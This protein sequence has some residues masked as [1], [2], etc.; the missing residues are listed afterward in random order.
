MGIRA[1]LPGLPRRGLGES[2]AGF[3]FNDSF[4]P[5]ASTQV[6]H[7]NGLSRSFRNQ[8]VRHINMNTKTY[9]QATARS[10]ESLLRKEPMTT[11]G[12][13]EVSLYGYLFDTG[14]D[15][16]VNDQIGAIDRSQDLTPRER[17]QLVSIL[18]AFKPKGLRSVDYHTA[19]TNARRIKIQTIYEKVTNT[20]ADFE[21]RVTPDIQNK[22]PEF[23]ESLSANVE[24]LKFS[25]NS[26]FT[27]TFQRDG[28][29]GDGV[30]TFKY[31]ENVDTGEGMDAMAKTVSVDEIAN[32]VNN[33]LEHPQG[34]AERELYEVGARLKARKQLERDITEEELA[35]E[36]EKIE[37]IKAVLRSG[38]V[39]SNIRLTD[40]LGLSSKPPVGMDERDVFDI[41][42][43]QQEQAHINGE[44]IQ[45]VTNSREYTAYN[46]NGNEF[47]RLHGGATAYNVHSS[48]NSQDI[49][50]IENASTSSLHPHHKEANTYRDIMDKA[51]TAEQKVAAALAKA[52]RELKSDADTEADKVKEKTW[53][54]RYPYVCFPLIA[55]GVFITVG[56]LAECLGASGGTPDWNKCANP[57][58]ERCKRKCFSD[59][60]DPSYWDAGGLYDKPTDGR[61]GKALHVGNDE[62]D[63]G[64]QFN[65]QWALVMWHEDRSETNPKDRYDSMNRAAWEDVPDKGLYCTTENLRMDPGNTTCDGYCEEACADAYPDRGFGS[66]FGRAA[67]EVV[68]LGVQGGVEVSKGVFD[69]IF[70]DNFFNGLLFVILLLV[71]FFLYKSF[72]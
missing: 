30:I 49:E 28:D 32:I 35:D 41:A 10:V 40:N 26:E 19:I 36:I 65:T 31:Y 18:P 21:P 22:F 11:V 67:R 47:G 68:K 37:D 72:K 38:S 59:W 53:C 4:D 8:A 54:A 1:D 9:D 13:N 52:R 46:P 15:A 25:K 51:E 43:Y 42:W 16:N 17:L 24:D 12:V 27:F 33:D 62:Y 39:Y 71:G 3:G 20:P 70:G 56:E 6:M 14:K 50:T 34:L 5:G 29:G 23:S 48:T 63:D 45:T 66:I 61:V 55:M 69:G 7:G 58:K 2:S 57:A 44:L 60:D 64:Y